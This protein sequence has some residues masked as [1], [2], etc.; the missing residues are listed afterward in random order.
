MGEKQK[1]ME[2]GKIG[3]V[4]SGLIGRS[5]AMI[6]AAAG[7]PVVLFDIKKEQ[8]DG[9]L[10]DIKNQ[11]NVLKSD[12]L[13]RGTLSP[14]EQM[15][16]ISGTDDLKIAV[17]NAIHIQ[18]CVPENP[19]LKKKVFFQIAQHCSESA[20][21]CSSTSCLMPSLIFEECGKTAQCIIAHPVNPPYYAPMVEIIPHDQTTNE[22]RQ[23][24]RSLMA[25][26]GQ[27]PVLLSR[28][29]DGFALNRIQ[30]A[31]INESWRLVQDGVLSPQDVDTVLTAGLGMR[32]ATIGPF[33]T[34]HLNAEGTREYMEKYSKTIQRVSSTF[35]PTPTYDGEALERIVGIMEKEIPLGDNM[36]ERRK[37]RDRLLAGMAKLWKDIDN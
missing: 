26:I 20:V 25:K 22:V 14:D 19:D 37:R 2:N 35:G 3:I 5:W 32:Y 6:F 29:V 23:K 33:E 18:E 27:K 28:A 7:H 36:A 15:A 30:Y 13:L 11:L 10:A 9:A 16:L 24:T 17:Q 34:I 31:V 12:G 21:I 4:G 1:K 8:V